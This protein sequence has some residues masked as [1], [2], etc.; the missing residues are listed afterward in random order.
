MDLFLLTAI[1]RFLFEG[2]ILVVMSRAEIQGW[3]GKEDT[4]VN[5]CDENI[6]GACGHTGMSPQDFKA[7]TNLSLLPDLEKSN[8]LRGQFHYLCLH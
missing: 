2:R 6:L 7:F 3:E 1:R 4:V 5:K 8:G